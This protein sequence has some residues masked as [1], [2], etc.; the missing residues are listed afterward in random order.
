MLAQQPTDMAN[1]PTISM[2]RRQ[3]MRRRAPVHGTSTQAT[4]KG[5]LDGSH[6]V[7]HLH[8]AA[9]PLHRSLRSLTHSTHSLSGSH[10]AGGTIPHPLP[11]TTLI[12][13]HPATMPALLTA[14]SSDGSTK[15]DLSIILGSIVAFLC[16]IA[17]IWFAR[18]LWKRIVQHF[19]SFTWPSSTSTP[20]PAP[21]TGLGGVTHATST[22]RRF[23]SWRKSSTEGSVYGGTRE[24]QASPPPSPSAPSQHTRSVSTFSGVSDG[25]QTFPVVSSPSPAYAVRNAPRVA[26]PPS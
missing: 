3:A 15:T 4:L 22:P 25:G 1:E 12:P 17:F 18:K 6:L 13:S 24:G 19:Q 26:A 20:T 8:S 16:M 21:A 23:K 7:L 11:Y 14:R 9:L 2:R 10:L 5:I